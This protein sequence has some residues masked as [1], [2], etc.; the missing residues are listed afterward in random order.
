MSRKAFVGGN[1][2]CNG[3]LASTA[4]LVTTLNGAPHTGQDI[5]VVVAPSAL[6]LLGVKSQ[7]EPKTLVA[8][9]NI[10]VQGVGAYTGETSAEMLVDAGIEW[11]ILGHSE[12]RHVYHETNE[13]T[14]QKVGVALTKGL[15][16]IACIGEKLD[17]REAGRTAEVCFAQLAAMLTH[18]P[19]WSKVVIAYEPV[20]AIGTGK[21]ASPEQAQEAHAQVRGWFSQHVSPDVAA[22]IRIIYG[23]SVTADNCSAL[24][25]LSDIDGFL[26]G[27]ASLKPDFVKIIASVKDR[28]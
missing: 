23:G 21:V 22:S 14:G 1:W 16:V 26:V 19:D 3:T 7:L 5:D 18:V 24:I 11:V 25:A 28:A 4:A 27:G 9:Q 8:A 13:L 12:R 17:E 2:K 20:W 15:H 6:H 10:N